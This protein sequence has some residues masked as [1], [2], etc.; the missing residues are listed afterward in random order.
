MTTVQIP[1]EIVHFY[2]DRARMTGS[3]TD[4]LIREAL[5]SQ[6]EDME[7]IAIADA[8]FAKGLTPIPMEQVVE[9]LG[10]DD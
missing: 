5:V 9:N 1:D 6:I 8:R 7:D 4:T 2:Q 3:D 10:L